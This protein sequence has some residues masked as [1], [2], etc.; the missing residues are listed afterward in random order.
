MKTMQ[1]FEKDVPFWKGNLHTH[2]TRSDGNLD[3]EAVKQ[4]Y[5][6][7]D[8]D[9]LALT[10][11]RILSEQPFEDQGL[12]MIP[13]I[14][15]D[16]MLPGEALH[17][18]GIGMK[19]TFDVAK[20]IAGGPQYC[21]DHM[22]ACGGRAIVAHPAW[23]LNTLATLSGLKDVTAVEIYNTTSGVPWNGARA[24]SSSIIDIAATHGCVHQVVASDDAHWYTGE[25]TVSATMIQAKEL[26]MESILE[27]LDRGQFYCTQGP[28]F[29]QI[30]MEDGV[31]H[32][33]CSPV[34]YI[35]FYSNAVWAAGRCK[36]G[37]NLTSASHDTKVNPSETFIRI[38]LIDH[39]GK[40][41]WS[42]PIVLK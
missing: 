13:G 37:E 29:E 3:P 10:D 15:M 33:K 16:Y 12:L 28:R 11:H 26:S 14:E 42:N 17:I 18:V 35:V 39:D 22:R 38:Q 24:D 27:A 2:T 6:D 30:S 7:K 40:N 32:V 31:V 36:T 9:F 20:G 1:I 4:C 19:D 25:Q 23:S 41:A 21:I 8:Y 34:K 5:R